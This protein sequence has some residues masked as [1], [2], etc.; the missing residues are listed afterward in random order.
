MVYFVLLKSSNFVLADVM[1]VSSLRLTGTCTA[2]TTQMKFR[3]TQEDSL[4]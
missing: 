2:S 4:M 1:K 3:L